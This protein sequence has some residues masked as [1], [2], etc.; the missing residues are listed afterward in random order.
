MDARIGTAPV[1]LRLDAEALA[2][3]AGMAP[4]L[5]NAQPWAFRVERDH[6]DVFLDRGRL[7]P[8]ADPADRQAPSVSVRPSPCCA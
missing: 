7:L 5:H 6:V 8:V 4:S 1:D 3:A 2:T